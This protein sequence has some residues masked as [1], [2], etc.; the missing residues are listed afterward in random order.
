MQSTG[1]PTQLDQVWAMVCR[2]LQQQIDPRDFRSWIV[3]LQVVSDQDG[4]VGLG[5]PNAFSRDWIREN[6]FDDICALWQ[7]FDPEK[8]QLCL[9]VLCLNTETINARV[10]D[11]TGAP[12]GPQANAAPAIALGA[13]FEKY[14]FDNFVVGPSNEVA[15]A[16]A[17]AA[18]RGPQARFNPLFI[19]G[20]YGL[21]KT[22]LL[23][24]IAH[25]AR[26][27]APTR[28]VS[29]LTA[30][31]FVQNFVSALRGS[32]SAEF[33]KKVRSLD[34]L[35]ID[36]IHFL[37]GKAATQEEFVHTLCSLIESGA[38]V[39]LSADRSPGEIASFDDRLRSHLN[40]GL[41]CRIAPAGFELRRD[42]L[43]NRI[44]EMADEFDGLDVP[45][46]VLDFLAAKVSTSPRELLG[47]LNMILSGTIMLGR[48]I[49][50][51][52]AQDILSDIVRA[53]RVKVSVADIQ[54]GTASWF[55][56]SK[57]DLLSRRKT[58]NIVRPRQI[59]M[60][61]AKQLT[62]SSLPMIGQRF[63]GRD[64][65]TVIHAVKTI[66]RLIDDDPLFANEVEGLR[67]SLTKLHSH[68]E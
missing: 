26:L 11:P 5:A 55:G 24:A 48:P 17:K 42:I 66:N 54:K 52:A 58:R 51:D 25:Q 34:L 33:K 57:E 16:M 44:A 61:L 12:T 19:H 9:T 22:H 39:V 63:D 2:Q 6:L 21:G 29:Y 15:W 7:Q 23:R 18:A 45:N 20:S 60:Y 47:A 14:R 3:R 1:D 64:H 40:G 4:R 56:L 49:T 35:L 37:A 43:S 41:V 32:Q 38:Q 59:A 68:N 28:R 27:H 67:R 30:E 46:P 13:S 53:T 8:R 31:D 62:S 10:E 50:L 36:D 65:T